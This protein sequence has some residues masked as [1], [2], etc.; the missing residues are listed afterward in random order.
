MGARA[1]L[2]E[3]LY[4]LAFHLALLA[5]EE[6]GKGQLVLLGD[7]LISVEGQERGRE[8]ALDHHEKK[9]FWALWLTHGTSPSQLGRHEGS[10][11]A[12]ADL[13][14]SEI[15]NTRELADAL[16]QLR[17]GAIYADPARV[18][19]LE[20]SPV[21]LESATWLIAGAERCLI[22]ARNTGLDHL[23]ADRLGDLRWFLTAGQDQRLRSLIWTKESLA[24]CAELGDVSLWVQWL[25]DR[26]REL[27]AA[28]R[29]QL[30]GEM[31]RTVSKDGPAFDPKWN[32][33]ARLFS[34][35]HTLSGRA[36][37]AWNKRM[38]WI[39]L[40]K[41]TGDVKAIDIE[42]KMPAIV[43]L[44]QLWPASWEYLTSVAAALSVGALG[45]VW[46]EQPRFVDKI[47]QR[48]EDIP[49]K[50]QVGVECTPK[51]RVAWHDG[52]FDEA[53]MTNSL[54][55]LAWMMRSKGAQMGEAVDAYKR[56]LAVMGKCDLLLR[57]EWN[58]FEE[59]FKATMQGLRTTGAWDGEGDGADAFIVHA[60][61]VITNPTVVRNYFAA[62]SG[63]MRRS[64][65]ATP[66][67][68]EEV[69]GMKVVCDL[70]FLEEARKAV[71]QMQPDAS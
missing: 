52:P 10:G 65:P 40:K 12:I 69:A 57:L 14:K 67:T 1:L 41:V 66:V 16:H 47:Y 50:C 44:T 18:P 29:E 68:L 9:I 22:R 21:G 8:G 17:L 6:V 26:Q 19:E 56:G 2:K 33:R 71:R 32:V 35:S 23:D 62:G 30:R 11:K 20:E 51:L 46:F 43:H 3:D 27:E 38:P 53:M 4:G 25:R 49:G 36:V 13:L 63:F 61:K 48:I 64:E 37:S 55:C 34:A 70:L 42:V 7:P 28:G 5:I 24:K 54:L 60:S 39:R 15:L 45:F 58:A 59:F 31:A